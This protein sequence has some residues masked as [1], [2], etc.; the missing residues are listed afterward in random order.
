MRAG[1]TFSGAAPVTTKVNSRGNT[2]DEDDLDLLKQINAAL[3]SSSKQN[4]KP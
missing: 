4:D 3:R 1:T 2:T